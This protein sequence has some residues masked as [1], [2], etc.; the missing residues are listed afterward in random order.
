[1]SCVC[2]GVE[3]A[4]SPS[5]CGTLNLEIVG[6]WRRPFVGEETWHEMARACTSE[7]FPAPQLRSETAPALPKDVQPHKLHS[8][9]HDK[10]DT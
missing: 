2:A 10:F 7:T 3:M 6:T 9:F 4:R 1:V 8:P 5:S